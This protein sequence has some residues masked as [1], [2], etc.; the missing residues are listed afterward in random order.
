MH[1]CENVSHFKLVLAFL[2]LIQSFTE[3][4]QE[5]VTKCKCNYE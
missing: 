4:L 1:Q 5:E 3:F 2:R